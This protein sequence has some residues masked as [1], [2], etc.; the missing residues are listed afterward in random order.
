MV[1]DELAQQLRRRDISLVTE[2]FETLLQIRID[3][4]RQSSNRFLR[5][6]HETVI[7]IFEHAS[8]RRCTRSHIRRFPWIKFWPGALAYPARQALAIR[9]G[10]PNIRSV[11]GARC[12]CRDANGA[13]AQVSHC[14]LTGKHCP[15]RTHHL[16]LASE[17]R[18]QSTFATHFS[19]RPPVRSRFMCRCR[20][21]MPVVRRATQP[22]LDRTAELS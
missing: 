3:Q 7:I 15:P 14:E 9:S 16:R 6:R 1:F 2:Q 4:E 22:H 13:I 20:H 11:V 19:P 17:Q 18:R 21:R 8:I 12:C 10:R 5:G